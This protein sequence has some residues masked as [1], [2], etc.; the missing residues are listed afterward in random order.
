MRGPSPLRS[1]HLAIIRV[2]ADEA[3]NVALNRSMAVKL[4]AC[5]QHALCAGVG[6]LRSYFGVAAFIAGLSVAGLPLGAHVAGM[7]VYCAHR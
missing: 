3:I 7:E 4:A 2:A 5:K 6:R 1:E